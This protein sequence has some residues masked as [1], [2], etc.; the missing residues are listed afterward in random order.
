[1]NERVRTYLIE[2]ARQ[3][4]K[5]VY[6]S[7]VVRDCGLDIDTGTESGRNE[8]SKI[9]G[10]VSV[11]E[12]QQPTPRPLLSSLAIYKDPGKNDHGD[13][14]YKI[15]AKLG[16]GTAKQLREE[17]WGFA[18]AE[19]CRQFWQDEENYLRYASVSQTRTKTIADLFFG[20]TESDKYA[21]TEDWKD[22]YLDFVKDVQLLQT[23][24]L[25]NPG[26]PI[27]DILL[28]HSLPKPIQ[29]YESFMRKWLK[30]KDNGISSRGHS[31]LSEVNFRKIIEDSG[32]KIITRELISHPSLENYNALTSW[33]YANDEIGNRPLL[34]N[35]AVAACN[36]ET[37]SSTVDNSKFWSVIEI[38]RESYGFEFSK[39]HLG[40]WYAAN[41]QL[42]AWLDIQLQDALP[43]KS[44]DRLEQLIWR[45]IF[46]WLI[47]DEFNTNKN[48][49]PNSLTKKEKPQN[50]FEDIPEDKKTFKGIKVD[51]A[52][53]AKDQKDLG[54][55]GEE[56]VMQYEIS[57]LKQNGLNEESKKVRIVLDG[58]GYDVYSFDTNG[59]EKFIEVKTTTGDELTPFY[60]SE[61]EVAFMQT[62]LNEYYIYRVYNYDEGNNSGEF[63]EIK[64]NVESQ[65]LMKPTQFKV[66]IKKI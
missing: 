55:A 58:E 48:A 1:M 30:E 39:D 20:L 23:S 8:L 65:L 60:M 7:D 28:Y 19:R 13:G 66:L 32:F 9:L 59:N 34:I 63:F 11:F 49:A 56:L 41:T 40:N 45:N 18:E 61:N 25:Q 38:V 54:D 46:V 27:D 53:K 26:T 50:G 2:A 52:A 47:Y 5:F 37:L 24:I 31:I 33:W 57:Y 3:N 62:H 17:L 10:D 42:T 64:N 51:F 29:S 43:K 4:G 14:F 22:V 21:W 35:R 15:A 44:T 6:Y 16:K 12:D 36:L